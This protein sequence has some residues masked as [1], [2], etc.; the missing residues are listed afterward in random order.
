MQPVPERTQWFSLEDG[1]RFTAERRQVAKLA[2]AL[3]EQADGN[4]GTAP[5]NGIQS[6]EAPVARV[7]VLP[8]EVEVCRCVRRSLPLLISRF[9]G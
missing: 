4:R 5:T 6:S 7:D 8:V 1:H 9:L 2:G 3:A